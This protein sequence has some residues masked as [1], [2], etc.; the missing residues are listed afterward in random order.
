MGIP[1]VAFWAAAEQ[2]GNALNL[3][4]DKTTNRYLTAEPPQPPVYTRPDKSE[5][6]LD[7]VPTTWFQSINP[8][9]IIVLA[10]PFAFLWTW[11]AR[12]GWNPSIP[13]KMALGVLLMSASM[14]I[15]SWS[16]A[17]EN[18]PTSVSYAGPIPDGFS[19]N[20][21][22]QLCKKQKDGTLVLVHQGR[23]TYDAQAHKFNMR[24]VLSDLDRDDIVGRTAPPGYVEALKDLQTQTQDKGGDG[25]VKLADVPPGFDLGYSGLDR[26]DQENHV[27]V[28][29]EPTQRLLEAHNYKLADKDM[30]ALLVAGGNEAF[31]TA[32]DNL[33]RD[34]SKHRVSSWWL[35]W[36]YVLT[37][38]GELCLSPIGLSMVSKL[39]PARFATMLMGLWMLTSFFGNFIAGALGEQA[40]F[41][42]PVTYFL[43]IT[44]V[45]GV[46]SLVVFVLA[47]LLVRLM[48]GVE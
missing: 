32:I 10:P 1:V 30:K 12:R 27:N 33:Y 4:A 29:F 44:V 3:W 2:A 6:W 42:P 40:E 25:A 8:L 14:G 45:L 28:T 31:R 37:T 36:F 9:A 41:T 38:V 21:Q 34:S 7:P 24:G 20:E 17:R 23:L 47:R 48:H 35:F 26:P 46:L 13:T 16:A 22:D 11:L 39:A 18:G 43:E 19:L 15:M 5:G